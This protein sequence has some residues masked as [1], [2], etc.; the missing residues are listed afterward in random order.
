MHGKNT[1]GFFMDV[2]QLKV[3]DASGI[4]YV[5][6]SRVRPIRRRD[7]EASL[8]LVEGQI[9]KWCSSKSHHLPNLQVTKELIQQT[10]LPGEDARDHPIVVWLIEGANEGAA[11][12][13]L[14]ELAPQQLLLETV[15]AVRE[16][17]DLAAAVE[18]AVADNKV[19]RTEALAIRR[20]ASE[21][22][23]RMSRMVNGVAGKV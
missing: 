23:A 22:S 21:L 19:T 1:R 12:H 10:M 11:L 5:S 7:I 16:V 20:E 2:D 14:P 8:D 13:D 18:L 6:V 9:D 4:V 15:S 17:G 3:M